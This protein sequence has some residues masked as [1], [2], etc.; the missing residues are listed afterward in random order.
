M[1]SAYT[2]TC[3][4]SFLE[5]AHL[6][7]W[8]PHAEPQETSEY[9]CTFPPESLRFGAPCHA[10]AFDEKVL[11]RPMASAN[12]NLH[13][14]LRA[15]LN[16]VLADLSHPPNLTGRVRDLVAGRMP[17]GMPTAR[18]LA[19]ELRM[20]PRTLFRKLESEGTAFRIE[21]DALRRELALQYVRQE[22]LP[23]IEVA[24]LLGFSHVPAFNRAF[25]RW[26]GATPTQY[27]AT[28]GA[29]P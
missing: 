26:T 8:F 3:Y 13:A 2:R 7:C 29:Q 9:E 27:R 21:L 23:L 18:S 12:A 28:Q 11:H 14:V 15:Q 22:D 5:N 17:S 1:S 19:Q 16:T 20:S 4:S 24:F 6:E 10:F 25:K